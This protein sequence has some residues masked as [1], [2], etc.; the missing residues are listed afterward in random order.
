MLL[1]D[2]STA[3]LS[4]IML[5]VYRLMRICKTSITAYFPHTDGLVERFHHTLTDVLAK[6]VKQGSKDCDLLLA[7]V[8]FTYHS[9]PQNFTGENPYLLYGSDPWLPTDS[10]LDVTE[11]Q[12]VMSLINYKVMVALLLPLSH[13]RVWIISSVAALD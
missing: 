8:L 13:A 5:D 4:K 7:Y 2:W 6:S 9:G 12:R 11:D 3:F 1:S 10:V